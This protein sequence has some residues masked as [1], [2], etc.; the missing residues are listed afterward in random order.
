MRLLTSCQ[1]LTLLLALIRCQGAG[2][3]SLHT[4]PSM[5]QASF[6]QALEQN[7]YP[8]WQPPPQ[9]NGRRLRSC[10]PLISVHLKEV[11]KPDE[12][13]WHLPSVN[14]ES[15]ALYQAT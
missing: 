4:R 11:N 8:C 6:R 14:T 9:R 1:Y 5:G 12:R 15:R 7:Q 2:A 13:L 3:S 10:R